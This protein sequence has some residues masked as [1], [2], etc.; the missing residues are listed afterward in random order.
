MNITYLRGGK[1]R[2]IRKATKVKGRPFPYG[3]Q[4]VPIFLIPGGGDRGIVIANS[5]PDKI[6]L[7]D[8]Y[9]DPEAGDR[10]L[11][12]WPGMNSQDVFLIDDVA[13][14]LAALKRVLH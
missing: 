11:A 12:A 1:R 8:Q 5:I 6:V 10:L 14:A 7:M 4:R 3:S 2:D 9:Y 13:L